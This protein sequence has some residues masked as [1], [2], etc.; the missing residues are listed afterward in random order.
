LRRYRRL[1]AAHDLVDAIE[2]EAADHVV[3]PV[4]ALP[5]L[6]SQAVRRPRSGKAMRRFGGGGAVVAA[7]CGIATEERRPQT[8][9]AGMG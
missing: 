3:E 5:G 6:Q 7:R 2:L 9:A 4:H 8:W 1:L